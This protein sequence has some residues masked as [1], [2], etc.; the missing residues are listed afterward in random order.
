MCGEGVGDPAPPPPEKKEGTRQGEG[1][2]RG[3]FV[4]VECEEEQSS[5]PVC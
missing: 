2:Y 1:E 5:N 3:A 4:T